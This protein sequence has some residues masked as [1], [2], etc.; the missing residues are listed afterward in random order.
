ML[1]VPKPAGRWLDAFGIPPLY[2][3]HGF[4]SEWLAISRQVYIHSDQKPITSTLRNFELYRVPDHRIT[5]EHF[6]NSCYS[7][8]ECT[9]TD[10]GTLATYRYSPLRRP[11]CLN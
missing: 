3:V 9:F 10:L 11:R 1:S 5:K 6:D 7:A 2:Q 4:E 8:I